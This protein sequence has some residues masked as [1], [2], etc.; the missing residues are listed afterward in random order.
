[1]E[2]HCRPSD[3]GLA[4]W[5]GKASVPCA[6]SPSAALAQL[7]RRELSVL[8]MIARGLRN[9]DIAEHLHLSLHTVKSHAQRINVKLG[10]SSRVQAVV[11]AKELSLIG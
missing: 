2:W 1:M 11:R 9:Q 10:V 8:Q 7:S 4:G 6:D 3:P 5:A